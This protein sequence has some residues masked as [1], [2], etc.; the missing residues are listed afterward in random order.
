MA[1][2]PGT[3]WGNMQGTPEMLM[4]GN[5]V[6]GHVIEEQIGARHRQDKVGYAVE[7]RPQRIRDHLRRPLPGR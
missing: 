6:A 4:P 3:S 7:V 5:Q 1:D 2:N